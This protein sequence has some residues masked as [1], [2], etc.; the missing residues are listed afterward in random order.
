MSRVRKKESARH[1]LWVALWVCVVCSALVTTAA[2]GLRPAQQLNKVQD[3]QRNILEA[4]GLLQTDQPLAA[5]AGRIETR[6]VELETGRFVAVD[7]PELYDQRRAAKDPARSVALARDRDPAVIKRRARLAQ[8][9]LVRDAAGR[10][11]TI[12]LPVHGYGLWSTL[13]GFLALQADTA[14]VVGLSFYEH[15]ETPGL[16]GEVDNPRWK[17]RWIGKR[18]YDENRRPAIRLVKRP[19]PPG[20]PDAVHQ[21]DAISGASLTMVGVEN[22]LNFWLGDVGYGPFLARLREEDAHG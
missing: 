15:A 7:D 17:A 14:T 20:H 1:T 3:K 12:V 6:L 16:G 5:L 4:A 22:L 10:I 11:E 13:Y 21:V 8:V 18:V 19:P 2:V 9:H